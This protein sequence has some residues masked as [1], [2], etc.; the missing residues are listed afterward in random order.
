MS[1]LTFT[2]L[3]S[4]T[5][6]ILLLTSIPFRHWPCDCHHHSLVSRLLVIRLHWFW[7]WLLTFR[8]FRRSPTWWNARR[9]LVRQHWFRHGL[10]G[11]DW[12]NEMFVKDVKNTFADFCKLTFNLHSLVIVRHCDVGKLSVHWHFRTFCQW[13]TLCNAR[14]QPGMST[15]FSWWTTLAYLPLLQTGCDGTDDSD[16]EFLSTW[17]LYPLLI[18]HTARARF[19]ILN[20]CTH[21]SVERLHWTLTDSLDKQDGHSTRVR[22]MGI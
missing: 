2:V 10:T 16:G 18:Y 3:L 19:P 15:L 9:Q 22:V 5:L 8:T 20:L 7:H 11:S 4:P 21:D 6:L 12:R 17:V 1:T 14:G 13:L